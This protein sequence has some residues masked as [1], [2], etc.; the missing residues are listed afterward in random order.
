MKRTPVTAPLPQ[1]PEV[2]HPFLR[3]A[4]IYDS[5]CSPEARVWFLDKDGGFY[6]KS[7]PKGTL[8]TEADLTAWFHSK[9]LAPEVLAYHSTDRDWL[10]TQAAT[11]ED[12]I[13]PGH[14]ADP[15]RLCDTTAILLRQLH[16]TDFT[17]CPVPNRIATYKAT[18]NANRQA[19]RFDLDLFLGDWRFSSP[20]EAWDLAQRHGHLLQKDTLLHGDYCLP[21]IL[22]DNW[23]FSAFID[24]GNGG[25]GDRHID[26]F[27]GTWT[28]MFNLKTDAYCSRFLDAYG[29]DRVE[30]EMLRLVAAYEVFG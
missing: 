24:L 7:A 10:L 22:L 11:G 1:F 3:N 4:T 8:N 14:L 18:A 25:V 9:D 12:C 28:L 29:R 6:L 2:L 17:G 27:W 15:K 23:R 30:P 26:I 16:E 19:G 20:E 13:H 5:S 21:N